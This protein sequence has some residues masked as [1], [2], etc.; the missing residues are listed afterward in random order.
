ML[1]ET[2]ATLVSWRHFRLGLALVCLQEY[3]FPLG[4]DVIY[5][6]LVKRAI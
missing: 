3:T 2:L 6:Q 1:A 5:I 4:E